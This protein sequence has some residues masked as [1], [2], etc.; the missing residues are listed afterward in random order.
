[1]QP[2]PSV[3]KMLMT[4][5]LQY[6]TVLKQ[7]MIAIKPAIKTAEGLFY[8]LLKT[9][10][11]KFIPPL[12]T[13]IPLPPILLQQPDPPAK[14]IAINAQQPQPV[15]QKPMIPVEMIKVSLTVQAVSAKMGLKNSVVLPKIIQIVQVRVQEL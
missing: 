11:A 14:Q 5:A 12:L 3:V 2:V 4:H 8:A 7:H 6:V 9:A 1:M 10:D 15:G 13:H